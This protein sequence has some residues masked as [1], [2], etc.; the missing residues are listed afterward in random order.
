M[1]AGIGIDMV[2]ISEISRLLGAGDPADISSLDPFFRRTF[3]DAELAMA[4]HRDNAAEFLAGRF[5]VKEAVFKSLAPYA[6]DNLEFHDIETLARQDGSP[7]VNPTPVLTRALEQAQA[8]EILVSITN[9][10][11]Y[12]V[13][14]ALSQ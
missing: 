11:N 7:Y 2:T 9:E 1:A 6:A 10:G 14:I 13:A 12:A 4:A 8:R 3:T 5:A